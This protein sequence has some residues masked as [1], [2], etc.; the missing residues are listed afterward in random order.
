M[1]I[2]SNFIVECMKPHYLS[3]IFMWL[4]SDF[5]KCWAHLTTFPSARAAIWD[6]SLFLG[7]LFPQNTTVSSRRILHTHTHTWLKPACFE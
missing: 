2:T 4:Q 1:I 7:Y 3:P 5:I 6:S